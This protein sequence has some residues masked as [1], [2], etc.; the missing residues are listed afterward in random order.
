MIRS[1]VVKQPASIL[2]VASNKP[3]TL[4]AREKHL[5]QQDDMKESGT[6]SHLNMDPAEERTLQLAVD[7][8]NKA[9]QVENKGLQFS[10]HEESKR[11]LVKVIDRNNDDEVVREVPPEEIID[12]IFEL[13]RMIGVL[14][15]KK[16]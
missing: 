1:E 2:G 9:V 15:D 10:V 8:L 13:Q 4:T 5:N 3:A 11:I 6:K 14:L 12:M 7:S 16:V